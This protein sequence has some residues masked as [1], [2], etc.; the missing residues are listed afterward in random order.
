MLNS[1]SSIH[2]HQRENS[3]GSQEQANA[4]NRP[5]KDSNH[6][7]ESSYSKTYGNLAQRQRS[8]KQGSFT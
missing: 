6:T 3:K 2:K 7:S 8:L 1:Y 4:Q 5:E